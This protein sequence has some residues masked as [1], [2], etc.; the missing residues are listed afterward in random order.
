MNESEGHSSRLPPPIA[1][2]ADLALRRRLSSQ[3]PMTPY[4]PSPCP[5]A[6]TLRPALTQQLCPLSRSTCR[7]FYHK[8][9]TRRGK[10]FQAPR[11]PPPLLPHICASLSRKSS[12]LQSPVSLLLCPLCP[13]PHQPTKAVLLGPQRPSACVSLEPHGGWS[14]SL[15]PSSNSRQCCRLPVL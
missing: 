4:A 8:T 1:V 2:S 13:A 5:Q 6:P 3:D 7:Y 10:P 15:G 11:K 14:L 9:K 12:L